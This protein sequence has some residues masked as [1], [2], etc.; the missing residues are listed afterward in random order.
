MT[1]QPPL[2]RMPWLCAYRPV[3][4]DPRPGQHS[5]VVAKPLEKRVPP[6]SNQYRVLGITS[7]VPSA[8]W[9]SVTM[10]KMFGRRS[11]ETGVVLVASA[12]GASTEATR[13]RTPTSMAGRPAGRERGPVFD[14]NGL[15]QHGH[16]P[17]R[18][19]IA[20]DRVRDDGTSG[21]GGA[22]GSERR[23]AP[24]PGA[25]PGSCNEAPASSF[26]L[27]PPQKRIFGDY[28]TNRIRTIREVSRDRGLDTNSLDGAQLCS[29]SV[30]R[31]EK[32]R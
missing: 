24:R 19:S 3:K 23:Y 10:S 22:S 1:S 6:C 14:L 13:R 18:C 9:S 8:R 15:S 29:D 12:L 31:L 20:L 32:A 25:S 28:S 11:A 2:V 5:V 21:S 27:S 16:L 26:V 7:S 17:S 4:I 30:P